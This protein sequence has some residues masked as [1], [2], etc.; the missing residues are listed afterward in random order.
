MTNA[1]ENYRV[2]SAT[3]YSPNHRTTIIRINFGSVLEAKYKCRA[4]SLEQRKRTTRSSILDRPSS[5]V[6]YPI[7]RCVRSAYKP[8]TERDCPEQLNQADYRKNMA[9]AQGKKGR[10]H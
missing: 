9:K 6:Q 4:N 5:R 1:L 10:V 2:V 3:I 7:N 8:Q